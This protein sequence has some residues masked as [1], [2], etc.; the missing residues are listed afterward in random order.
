MNKPTVKCFKWVRGVN[1][2]EY[3]ELLLNALDRQ[4]KITAK[5]IDKLKKVDAVPV[6]YGEWNGWTATHWTGKKDDWGDPIYKEHIYYKCSECGRRTVIREKFCPNC[7]A[8]MDG[9]RQEE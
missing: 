5:A 3:I 9:E 6:K 2:A 7:G 1:D 8:K 4:K